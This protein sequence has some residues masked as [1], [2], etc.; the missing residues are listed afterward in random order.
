MKWQTCEWCGR[1]VPPGSAVAVD[2]ELICCGSACAAALADEID[3]ARPGILDSVP[4][5]DLDVGPMPVVVTGQG[6]Y[7]RRWPAA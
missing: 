2:A 6:D 1:T 7:A 5:A 4:I 3:N